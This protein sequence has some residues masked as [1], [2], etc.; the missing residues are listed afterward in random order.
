MAKRKNI[1]KKLLKKLEKNWREKKNSSSL[2]VK[3][4]PNQTNV[5]AI[6]RHTEV[7]A[8]G[9]IEECFF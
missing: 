5:R 3:N 7:V 4:V 1:Q 8:A 9:R 2:M 6:M